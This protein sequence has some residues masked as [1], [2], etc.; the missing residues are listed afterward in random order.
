MKTTVLIVDDEPLVRWSLRQRMEQE[1]YAVLEAEDGARAMQHFDAL[2]DVV[3]LDLHLPDIDG[4]EVLHRMRELDPNAVVIMLT[5]HASVDRAV[6]AMQA[7]AHH[8]ASKPFDLEVVALVVR[9]ALETT[10]LRREVRRLRAERSVARGVG[11]IIGESASMRATKELIRRIAQSPTSTVLVTGES[12]TGK[13]LVA[14]AI[15]AHSARSAGP[16]TNITCSALPEALLESELFGHE[17]GAFTDARQLKKGLLEQSDGGTVFLDEIGEMAP[18]LQAKL[19][20]FLEEKAFRRVGGN[21]DIR[22]NVRIVAA[23]NIDLLQAVR[24]RQFREDLYYRLN[25]LTVRLPSLR[26][27]PGDIPLLAKCFVDLYNREFDKHVNRISAA[28]LRALEE[29]SWPGNVREL[30]NTFERAMLL[31]DGETLHAHD[32]SVQPSAPPLDAFEL[33]VAG[34]DL[35]ELERR[36]V[37][38]ALERTHGNHT[39]AARLLGMNRD[40]IRYRIGKYGLTVNRRDGRVSQ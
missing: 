15:H 29:H 16:F 31:C 4:L 19:L 3:L 20:R 25:V 17:R 13:D 11:E 38:Q 23:T 24:D 40:Q 28:A 37:I 32:V 7:G 10:A 36:L 34:I 30:R 2:P 1:G 6:E 26:E 9:R 21:A 22:P 18:S 5:A 27:R 14:H 8:Y 33:P 39:R 35:R 12:G